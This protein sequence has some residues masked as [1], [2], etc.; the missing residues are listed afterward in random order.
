MKKQYKEDISR[1]DFYPA[2]EYNEVVLIDEFDKDIEGE[3]PFD[4]E[5]HLY[6]MM[7]DN[8]YLKLSCSGGK[9]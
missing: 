3:L 7:K 4:F 8:E 9:N 2:L 6:E 1:Y 5:D